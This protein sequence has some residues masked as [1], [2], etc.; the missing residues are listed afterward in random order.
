VTKEATTP[1]C[2]RGSASPALQLIV[3]RKC[4]TREDLILASHQRTELGPGSGCPASAS[5]SARPPGVG[6]PEVLRASL[7]AINPVE[8]EQDA[9][10][11]GRGTGNP[12]CGCR[13]RTGHAPQEGKPDHRSW[14]NCHS[15]AVGVM[16]FDAPALKGHVRRALPSDRPVGV[17]GNF[18]G[19]LGR[20]T[21]NPSWGR[22]N[23]PC[24]CLTPGAPPSGDERRDSV[25]LRPDADGLI[26]SCHRL[27][28]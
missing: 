8:C 25:W 6:F 5:R 18:E 9:Q 3:G 21:M 22:G 23:M 1:I 27:T 19:Q 17:D 10:Q 2:G 16:L 14:V 26:A 7:S 20:H 13:P 4:L 24:R 15:R 28:P 12:S 11:R